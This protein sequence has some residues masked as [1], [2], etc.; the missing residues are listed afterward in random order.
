MSLFFD[1]GTYGSG[2]HA[3]DDEN[4]VRQ[5]WRELISDRMPEAAT[6]NKWPVAFDH[7]FARILLDNTIGEPWRNVIPPPAWKNTPIRT[8]ARAISLG[9][10][11]LEHPHLLSEFNSRSLAL[12][13]KRIRRLAGKLNNR[14]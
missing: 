14:F 5:R 8:L 2:A 6:V 13:G 12:R 1:K 4:C 3:N 11:A 7:C 10:L 9:E